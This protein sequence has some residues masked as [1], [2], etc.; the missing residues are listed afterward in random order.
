MM[1]AHDVAVFVETQDPAVAAAVL[2]PVKPLVEESI[3]SKMIWVIGY[4]LRQASCLALDLTGVLLQ[5]ASR[6]YL[7]SCLVHGLR[8]P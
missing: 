6:G 7:Q 5:V 3:S 8:R 2:G 1:L 4:Y